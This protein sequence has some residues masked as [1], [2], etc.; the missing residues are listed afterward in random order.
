[1]NIFLPYE[2]LQLSVEALDDKRLLKQIL[3]I[4]QLLKLTIREH[5]GATLVGGYANHPIYKW[6][7][8]YPGFM[9][10]YGY[11][12]CE[13]YSYRFSKVHRYANDFAILC[14]LIPMSAVRPIYIAGSGSAQVRNTDNYQCLYR[15]KLAKKWS[16]SK[17]KWTRRSIPDFAKQQEDEE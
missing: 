15:A 6:Y 12:A 16:E 5:D 11:L 3:E 14:G 9:A 2:N 10:E 7:K 8:D 17:P 1:M 13:E 4:Y